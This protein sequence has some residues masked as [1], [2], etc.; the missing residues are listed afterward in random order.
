[1]FRSFAMALAAASALAGAPALAQPYPSQPIKFIVP[2]T[3]GT[4]MDTIARTVGPRLAQRLGQPVV[5]ENRPGASGNIGA[6]A[7]ARAAPDGYTLLVGANTML[8]AANLY[9]NVPFD[10][11]NDFAPLT[12]AAW[13]TLLLVANPNAGI[14]S[15]AALVAQARAQ[16]GKIAYSSPGIGTPHHM[17]M[18]LFKERTGVD[19]LHVPYKGSAGA[20]TDLLS[21]AVS[22]G[23]VPVHVAL[24]LIKAGKLK[25]LA[26]GSPKRH[27]SAPDVPTLDELGYKGVDVEMW[28]PILAPKGTPAAITAK[29]SGEL[30][31]ILSE[32]EV[33]ATFDKVGLDAAS[34]P[35]EE[36]RALMERDYPRWAEV[37]RKNRIS[38]E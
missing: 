18:E 9:K 25:A 14:D 16:P 35:P 17:S 23:F 1:M 6:E 20:L 28:Y 5:V 31:A 15:V 30:R 27:P 33:K 24:P 7:V 21:G 8:I 32:P 29:L 3:P 19:L 11:I 2:F 34:M 13:G 36:L 12:L 26:A 10:P 38:A 22:V 4:G 37:I